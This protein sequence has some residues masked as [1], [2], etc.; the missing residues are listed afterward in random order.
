MERQLSEG[1]ELGVLGINLGFENLAMRMK[2]G[3]E[4][5]ES[6]L[7][8]MPSNKEGVKVKGHIDEQ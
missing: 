2:E 1:M 6:V 7:Q 8:D 5:L 3:G 4:N